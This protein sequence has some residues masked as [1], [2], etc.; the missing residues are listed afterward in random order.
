MGHTCHASVF[1]GYKIPADVIYDA[2]LNHG[3]K[4]GCDHP[5]TSAKFCGECGAPM[6]RDVDDDRSLHDLEYELVPDENRDAMKIETHILQDP[7]ARYGEPMQQQTIALIIGHRFEINAHN[8]NCCKVYDMSQAAK[9]KFI[10]AVQRLLNKID[11]AA[12]E[13]GMWLTF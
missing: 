8:K 5:E 12:M 2:Y 10:P 6:W 3:K 13:W 7:K 9:D 1:V 11:P 4:R